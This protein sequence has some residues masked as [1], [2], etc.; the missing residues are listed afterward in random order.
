MRPRK[1]RGQTWSE[2]SLSAA[3]EAVQ[4]GEL[5]MHAASRKY[6]IPRWTLRNHVISGSKVKRLGRRGI[7]TAAQEKEL[8]FLLE[9]FAK[10]GV[11]ITS[12]LIRQEAFLYCERNQLK[13]NF[14]KRQRMAGIEWLRQFIKR[15]PSVGKLRVIPNQ[16]KK[17]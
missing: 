7:M 5:S 12:K 9:G 16:L 2:E 1:N 11:T 6:K 13:H 8:I 3:M 4:R 17:P 15:N 10:T 14:N